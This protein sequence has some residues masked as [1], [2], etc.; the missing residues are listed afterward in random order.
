MGG[1]AARFVTVTVFAIGELLGYPTARD[2][3]FPE[4][5]IMA[6]AGL[7]VNAGSNYRRASISRRHSVLDG[8][9]DLPAVWRSSSHDGGGT[10]RKSVSSI[11]ERLGVER[12]PA[13][14]SGDDR[15][16]LRLSVGP[17]GRQQIFLKQSLCPTSIRNGT[18]DMK[19]VDTLRFGQPLAS[20]DRSIPGNFASL[21]A[22]TS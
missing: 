20:R 14:D 16:P 19:N 11:G 7:L 18:D 17:Q 1:A 2:E 3:P 5:Y 8:S 4:V 13:L 15:D 10:R 6:I 12:G 9:L 21:F 22:E